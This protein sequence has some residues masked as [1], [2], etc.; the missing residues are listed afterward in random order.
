MMTVEKLR[1]AL[2]DVPGDAVVQVCV[3]G[4]NHA[5]VERTE[6]E[7]PWADGEPGKFLIFMSENSDI[8]RLLPEVGRE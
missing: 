2:K 3:P 7:W 1:R 8:V 4:L 5:P 6:W